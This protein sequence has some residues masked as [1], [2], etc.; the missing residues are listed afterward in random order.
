MDEITISDLLDH[1]VMINLDKDTKRLLRV[2]EQFT[3]KGLTK[4]QRICAVFGK[5][6]S[7]ISVLR[8]DMKTSGE[9]DSVIGCA[10]SHLL[11][12]K[13]IIDNGWDYGLILED[14]IT[15]TDSLENAMNVTV[16]NDWDVL[17]L[18]HCRGKWPRN[19]CS[20]VQ[21]YNSEH[22]LRTERF[23]K[24]KSTKNAPMGTW[25]YA[26][27]AETAQY[28]LDNYRLVEPIDV[29]IVSQNMLNGKNVYG[30]VP[31]LITHCYDFGSHTARKG[32]ETGWRRS[33][34]KIVITIVLIVLIFVCVIAHAKTR[35]TR[36]KIGLVIA[37]LFIM[38]SLAWFIAHC[39]RKSNRQCYEYGIDPFDPFASVWTE[40]SRNKCSLLLERINRK[41]NVIIAYGSLLGWARHDGTII[42]WDDDVDVLMM[43]KDALALIEELKTDPSIIITQGN[44]NYNAKI[45]WRAG[46]PIPGYEYT[47]PFIDIFYYKA[48]IDNVEIPL[49]KQ[50]IGLDGPF[51]TFTSRFEGVT[52]QIPT[53][54]A[55]ILNT[56][57][58]K[59]WMT[60]C[61]SSSWNHRQECGIDKRYVKRIKCDLL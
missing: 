53:E 54:Y 49:L 26:V 9:A 31:S 13:T 18:G 30:T 40:S 29:F 41:R 33:K 20:S 57:Y 28:V 10:L 59:K 5:E 22:T 46:D 48:G 23:I 55:I 38:V 14:D 8:E 17:F 39:A 2:N 21:D 36:V 11:A 4:P 24:F 34:R 32:V 52:V 15:L 35:D 56:L 45:S 6:L 61:V 25:A 3:K 19:A 1:A 47:H 60:E 37:M 51:T 7:N 50:R 27:T 12:Y 43:E 58:D 42:P 16:P 44:A